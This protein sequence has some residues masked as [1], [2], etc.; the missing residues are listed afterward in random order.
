MDDDS[1]AAFSNALRRLAVAGEGGGA[2]VLPDRVVRGI[3][4]PEL[5]FFNV[6]VLFRLEKTLENQ[7]KTG[8]KETCLKPV[9]EVQIWSGFF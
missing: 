9:I 4:S 8:K 3:C 5:C 6:R 2:I 1:V 7:L